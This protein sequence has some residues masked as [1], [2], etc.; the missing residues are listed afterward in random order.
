MVSVHDRASTVYQPSRP[1]TAGIQT[2]L[3]TL[4][5]AGLAARLFMTKGLWIGIAG[6]IQISDLSPTSTSLTAKLPRTPSDW[7]SVTTRIQT[8]VTSFVNT[9]RAARLSMILENSLSTTAHIS[10]ALWPANMTLAAEHLLERKPWR[11][12]CTCIQKNDLLLVPT[13]VVTGAFV[14]LEA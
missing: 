10:N 14:I 6:H 8:S 2:H 9:T 4:V 12:I 5:T 11:H 3:L 13:Q 7:I 1:I